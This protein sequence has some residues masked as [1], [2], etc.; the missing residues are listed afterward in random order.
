MRETILKNFLLGCYFSLPYVAEYKIIAFAV[1]VQG[2]FKVEHFSLFWL[3]VFW[4]ILKGSCCNAEIRIFMS[5][6][7]T[8]MVLFVNGNSVR[9]FYLQATLH[10]KKVFLRTNIQF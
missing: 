5:C 9:L 7:H 10:Q 8:D 3:W 2:E 4:K 1:I 6:R